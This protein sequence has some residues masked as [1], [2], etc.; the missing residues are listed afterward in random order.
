LLI[1]FIREFGKRILYL[2]LNIQIYFHK[3]YLIL[4]EN[5]KHNEIGLKNNLMFLNNE[6]NEYKTKVLTIFCKL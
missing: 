3:K 6:A 4:E 2:S 1:A 5:S